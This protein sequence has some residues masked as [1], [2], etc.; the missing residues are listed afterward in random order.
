LQRT[1]EHGVFGMTDLAD[2][3]AV[4]L[5]TTWRLPNEFAE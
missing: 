5:S 3:D 2:V 1:E 4:E